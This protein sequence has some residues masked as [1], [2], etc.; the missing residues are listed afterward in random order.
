M[1]CEVTVRIVVRVCAATSTS[2]CP[3]DRL[4]GSHV[5]HACRRQ[6]PVAKAGITCE[7]SRRLNALRPC[8][9]FTPSAAA[10]VLDTLAS[11]C[12]STTNLTILHRSYAIVY[13]EV[14]CRIV[15][16]VCT[17]A[18]SIFPPIDRHERLHVGK[19]C[20]GQRT[21]AEACEAIHGR[22]G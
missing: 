20:C 6:L 13:I 8:P 5:R 7:W 2:F 3:I 19:S 4:K 15:P 10:F 22:R 12:D 17:T 21:I 14:A 9:N 11:S 1:H 16:S 18:S